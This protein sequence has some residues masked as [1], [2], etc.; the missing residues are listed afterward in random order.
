MDRTEI[1]IAGTGGQGVILAGILLAEAA[2]RDGK[3]VVQTQAYGPSARGSA[4]RSEVIIS[5]QEIDYPEVL[6]ADILLCLSQDAC[7]R[8]ASR[9]KKGGMLILDTT[10]VYR[11]PLIGAVR[12]PI[13]ELAR[14]ATG[15]EITANMVALGLLVGLTGVVSRESLEAAVRA[16]AP[17]GTVE[18]NLKALEVGLEY[19]H[20]L[21]QG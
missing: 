9:L 14:Q 20:R 6:D 17:D 5:D 7:D 16:R 15:R 8:Y 3:Q 11:A 10:H 19:A 18:I 13:T 21:G 1:R 12:V 4:S 2:V